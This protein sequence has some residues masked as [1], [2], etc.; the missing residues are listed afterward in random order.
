M[1]YYY[2]G[3]GLKLAEKPL[4]TFISLKYLVCYSASSH[5]NKHGGGG[6]R[7]W[8]FNGSGREAESDMFQMFY[9]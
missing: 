3:K 6:L 1:I 7:D 5:L 2:R 9:D 4:I 8:A